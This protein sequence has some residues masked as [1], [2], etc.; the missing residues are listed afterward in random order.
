[1]RGTAMH[2]GVQRIAILAA[3]SWV[4]A[5]A[6]AQP[7]ARPSGPPSGPAQGAAAD[8]AKDA[9]QAVSDAGK[10]AGAAAGDAAKAAGG[11]VKDAAA[12]AGQAGEGAANAAKAAA[13]AVAAPE[14]PVDSTKDAP[15]RQEKPAPLASQAPFQAPVPAE[16]RLRNGARLLV[17]ENHS[18]P[19]V[20][21]TVLIKTGNDGDPVVKAGLADFVA[22]MLT[23][24][25]ST[26][27]APQVSEAI[28]DL[29]AHLDASAGPETTRVT[30]NCLKETLPKALDVLTDVLTRPAFRPEDMERVRGL[31]LTELV[32][33]NANPA[34]IAR[35]EMDRLLYGE[36]HP[37]GQPSGGTPD[38]LRGIGPADLQRFHDTWYRP[39][40][41]IVS[42]A[43]DLT[44]E[45]AKTMLD[46]RL[47]QW[48]P[49]PL[50]KLHLPPLPALGA[51]TVTLVDKPNASQSQV[52]TVGRLFP[53]RDPDAVPLRVANYILGGLFG[54]RLNLNLRENKGY[55]YGVRSSVNLMKGTGYLLASGGIVA[56]NTAEALVEYEKELRSFST[57]QV[58]DEE[59]ARAKEAYSRSLPSL[60]ETNDAVAASIAT[61]A[62]LG[63][64]L[65][66]FRKL[67]ER[68]AHVGKSEVAR[69]AR[70]WVRPDAWPVIIVGPRSLSEEKL[71][72]MG[73]GA[74]KVR[75]VEAAPTAQSP[76]TSG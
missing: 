55:S 63:L 37:W 2:G 24:G 43:G 17:V 1:M 76:A 16:S 9:A 68:I 60:L 21:V 27:T 36:K 29:A 64:P 69:V 67:P 40:N 26:K 51:R 7:E 45:E 20:A 48:S 74:V 3:L 25:T 75:G 32:Q 58:T 33:K 19:L 4:L 5:C 31:M 57:G 56:K 6:S 18:V 11:P 8:G 59:L 14:T 54:S 70:K 73:F 61:I 28:E 65:D 15:F 66:Y 53:A 44:P 42:V 72:G 47:A 30:L 10:K 52:W 41:A 46:E 23:E 49:K 22:G 34:Q 13:G 39:N 62:F 35:D 71:K 38:S 12:A 50:P